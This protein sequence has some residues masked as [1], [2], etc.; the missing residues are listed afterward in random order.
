MNQPE[1]NTPE[2]GNSGGKP[3]S[4]EA[5]DIAR[6]RPPRTLRLAEE[7]MLLLLDEAG[8]AFNRVPALQRDLCPGRVGCVG[9]SR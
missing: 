4:Q 3:G 1:T 6:E 9:P 2:A 5:V 8:S 7:I